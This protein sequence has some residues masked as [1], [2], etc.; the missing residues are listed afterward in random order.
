MIS[1]MTGNSPS[2]GGGRG[3]GV[4][5]DAYMV[6]WFIKNGTSQKKHTHKNSVGIGVQTGFMQDM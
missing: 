2:G 1:A 5:A 4:E 3:G 6:I